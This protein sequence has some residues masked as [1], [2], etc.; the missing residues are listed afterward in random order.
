MYYSKD[1]SKEKKPCLSNSV[2]VLHRLS[3]RGKGV[4]PLK[5]PSSGLLVISLKKTAVPATD[6]FH[7]GMAYFDLFVTFVW[8]P[9]IS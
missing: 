5:N 4:F 1:S 8:V 7:F 2:G 9:K 6:S 3:L